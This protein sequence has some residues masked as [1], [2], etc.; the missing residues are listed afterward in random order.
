MQQKKKIHYAFAM[1]C[2]AQLLQHEDSN[3]KQHP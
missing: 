1:Q 3:K 2:T